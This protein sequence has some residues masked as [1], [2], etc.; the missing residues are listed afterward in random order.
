LI[1]GG[2][3]FTVR[4]EMGGEMSMCLWGESVCMPRSY[5]LPCSK[6]GGVGFYQHVL[7]IKSSLALSGCV[8]C[9]Y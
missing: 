6:K 8:V 7:L 9:R 1:A 3:Y 4:V 2:N 5:H